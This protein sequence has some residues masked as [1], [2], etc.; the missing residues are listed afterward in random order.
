MR[1]CTRHKAVGDDVLVR[2]SRGKDMNGLGDRSFNLEAMPE[3]I[4]G[5]PHL[6]FVI[7]V[8]QL[9]ILEEFQLR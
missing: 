4:S 2:D 1:P 8:L 3:T 5:E 6:F 9:L 7:G